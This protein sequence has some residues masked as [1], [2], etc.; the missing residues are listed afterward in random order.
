MYKD[1]KKKLKRRG[2]EGRE[3]VVLSAGM[4]RVIYGPYHITCN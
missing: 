2:G 4:V 1:K 3:G